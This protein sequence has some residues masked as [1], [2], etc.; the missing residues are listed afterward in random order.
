M[1]SPHVAGALALLASADN[2]ANQTDVYALYGAVVDAGN[3]NWTDD[4]GDGIQ[5]PLLDVSTFVPVMVGEQPP[6]NLPPTAAF[7]HTATG[8]VVNFTDTSTDSDG[9]ISSWSWNFGDGSGSTLKNP[10]HTYAGDGTYTVTLTV[11]DDGSLKDTASSS[12]TV[13]A[14]QTGEISLTVETRKAGRN[15]YADL[16]WE[17]ATGATVDVYRNDAK[18]LTTTNDGLYSEK[19]TSFVGDVLTYKVCNT[20]TSV[21]SNEAIVS[22]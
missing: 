10:S 17:G 5:E 21:C 14:P 18:L 22:W 12:V 15:T 3:D 7:T 16:R 13:T 11:T 19:V 9:T 20:G 6:A 1:A 4:S 8:L 2:P